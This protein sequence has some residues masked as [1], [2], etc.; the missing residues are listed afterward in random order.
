MNATRHSNCT[1]IPSP[2]ASKLYLGKP[3]LTITLLHTTT[4]LFSILT[5]F[6]AT[7]HRRN[8]L[9]ISSISSSSFDN[10]V[11]LRARHVGIILASPVFFAFTNMGIILFPDFQNVGNALQAITVASTLYAYGN[12]IWLTLG[13]ELGLAITKNHNGW[14]Q[15]H[16]PQR[17]L[18]AKPCCCLAVLCCTKPRHLKKRDILCMS[19]GLRQFVI[20][21]PFTSF[22]AMV[23]ESRL[24]STSRDTMFIFCTVLD[25]VSKMIAVYSMQIFVREASQTKMNAIHTFGRKLKSIVL[26]LFLQSALPN[27]LTNLMGDV[28]M[29]LNNGMVLPSDIVIA[30]IVAT[31]ASVLVFV[32]TLIHVK[33]NYPLKDARLWDGNG[34]SDSDQ[35]DVNDVNM[36]ESSERMS[37]IFEKFKVMDIKLLNRFLSRIEYIRDNRVMELEMSGGDREMI[38]L[39]D[40]G[41]SLSAVGEVIL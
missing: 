34:K 25:I 16:S 32:V 24:T 21:V 9:K 23:S 22:L 33:I 11:P 2:H 30:L 15:R 13:G 12:Y 28:S 35:V 26:L 37:L 39:R 27:I 36:I 6:I 19:R 14:L 5:F 3:T 10:I 41:S 1:A 20:I 4:I 29:Q 7:N 18:C 38:D 17:I 40:A 8:Y 31:I